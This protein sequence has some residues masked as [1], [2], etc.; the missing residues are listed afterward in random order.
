M[1]MKN[2]TMDNTTTTGRST[3]SRRQRNHLLLIGWCGM[4]A[5]YYSEYDE[6]VRDINAITGEYELLHT[7]R[8]RDEQLHIPTEDETSGGTEHGK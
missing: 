2:A 5:Y 1:D 6:S 4:D 8:E 3:G 7:L